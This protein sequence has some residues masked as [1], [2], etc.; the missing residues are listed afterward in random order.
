MTTRLFIYGTLLHGEDN[1]YLLGGRQPLATVVSEPVYRML[2]MGGYPALTEGGAT[3]IVG[4][5]YEVDVAT[6]ARLDILEEVPELYRRVATVVEGQAVELYVMP[7]IHAVG[8]VIIPSG[9]WRNWLTGLT[10]RTGAQRR[11]GA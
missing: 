8:G 1:H 10:R 3:A 7:S 4:E 5:L 11:T 6:L 2:D 9:N